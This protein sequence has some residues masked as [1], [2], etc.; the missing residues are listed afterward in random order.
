M[1]DDDNEEDVNL[2]RTGS[3]KRFWACDHACGIFGDGG[4]SRRVGF[5]GSGLDESM[6]LSC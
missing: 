4:P 6:R 5:S 1:E 2:Q 3:Q